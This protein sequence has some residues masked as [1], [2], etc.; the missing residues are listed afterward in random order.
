MINKVILLGN[1]GGDPEVRYTQAG[2]AIANFSVATAERFKDR[3]GQPQEKTEWHRV[4]AFGRLAEVCGEYLH[5]GKQVY[6]EGKIQ[7][8]K[9]QDKDG[10]DR[11]ST[12]VVAGEMKM[13]GQKGDGQQ[14]GQGRSQGGRSQQGGQSQRGGH[15]RQ[16]QAPPPPDDD[17]EDDIPF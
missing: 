7:T 6:I 9:W 16:G 15:S 12:E 4:V 10:I 1:L 14:Q 8:R 17:F 5:K 11:Y 3:D 2:L 13:L